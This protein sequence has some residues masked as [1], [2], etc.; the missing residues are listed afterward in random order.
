MKQFADAAGNAWI[1]SVTI[2]AFERIEAITGI[3]LTDLTATRQGKAMPVGVEVTTNYKL[4]GNVLYAVCQPQA[5]R[6]G[7]TQK[8]FIDLLSGEVM[9]QAFAC[10]ADEMTSFFRSMNRQ[11]QVAVLE[12]QMEVLT[13]AAD[14]AGQAVREKDPRQLIE[15]V[16]R[17]M[18]PPDSGKASGK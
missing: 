5:E 10:F 16:Q 15:E 3:D 8:D 9:A 17:K 2:G 14:L 1:V 12:K 11:D 7:L 6:L 4:L 13:M 18:R